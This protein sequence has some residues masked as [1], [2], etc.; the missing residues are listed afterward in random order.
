LRIW[1]NGSQL[2]NVEYL[3]KSIAFGKM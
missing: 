3:K 2:E 1:N